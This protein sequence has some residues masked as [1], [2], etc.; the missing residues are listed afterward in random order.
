MKFNKE[1]YINYLE[2]NMRN[3]ADSINSFLKQN[4]PNKELIIIYSKSSDLT[5]KYLNKINRE[6]LMLMVRIM[7]NIN[8]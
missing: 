7:Y 5:L 8:L 3:L 6:T 2:F 1:N 4:Y